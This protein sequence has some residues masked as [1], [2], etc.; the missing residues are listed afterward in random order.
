MKKTVGLRVNTDKT[1]LMMARNCGQADNIVVD[2][3][4]TGI[5]A[6]F[7]YLGSVILKHQ[8]V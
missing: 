6:D 7:C 5:V 2:G 3:K 1:K 4:N 8:F